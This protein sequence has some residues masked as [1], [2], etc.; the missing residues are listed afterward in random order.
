[1]QGDEVHGSIRLEPF[2]YND[3]EGSNLIFDNVL[4]QQCKRSVN[5]FVGLRNRHC[6]R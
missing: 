4:S 6:N 5:L 2:E 1:L 3:T